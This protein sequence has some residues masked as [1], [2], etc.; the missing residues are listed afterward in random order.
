MIALTFYPENLTDASTV[1]NKKECH[2]GLNGIPLYTFDSE[3]CLLLPGE[4]AFEKTL[5]PRTLS[6]RFFKQVLSKAQESA[7]CGLRALFI[8]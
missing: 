5:S 8:F 1:F 4:K 6:S 7:R 3:F 2:M